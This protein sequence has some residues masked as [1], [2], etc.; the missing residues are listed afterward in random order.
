M[1]KE[2]VKRGCAK[3]WRLC[4][5]RADSGEIL[6]ETL[7]AWRGYF[8][9][10]AFQRRG[11]TAAHSIYARKRWRRTAQKRREPIKHPASP[12]EGHG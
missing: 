10:D 5:S 4:K 1:Q 3:L 6:A 9:K 7:K 11:L 12:G 8:L 2:T